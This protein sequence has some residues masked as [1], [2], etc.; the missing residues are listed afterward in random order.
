[1]CGILGLVRSSATPVAPSAPLRRATAIV[2]HRGPDDEGYTL[3]CLGRAPQVYSGADTTDASRAFHNLGALPD[4]AEW[5]VGF[6]HRRLSIVDLTPAGHQPMVH[7][8]TGITVVYSGEIY[9]HVELRRELAKMGHEFVSHSDT[10]V[11]LAAWVE[12]GP[13]CT[14]HFNGM[15]AFLVLDPRGGG[16]LHAVRDRFGVKPLYWARVGEFVAFASEIK[17]IRSLPA[18]YA[19]LDES[20][21]RDYLVSGVVDLGSHTFDSE[22]RQLEPGCSAI[23]RLDDA[24]TRVVT[25]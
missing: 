6:G 7:P 5:K 25:S 19:R 3:W 8:A 13:R 24:S 20:T 17:Q 16:T 10:E 21:V 15:F 22:I 14:E 23:V 12:W 2:R 11:L 1:M 9:N 18:S 4:V